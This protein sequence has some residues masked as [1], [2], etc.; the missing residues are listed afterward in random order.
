MVRLTHPVVAQNDQFD[1][2]A[3][4]F[5]GFDSRQGFVWMTEASEASTCV[6]LT[7]QRIALL[8]SSMRHFAQALCAAGRPPSKSA[9]KTK[10]LD[11]AMVQRIHA[12][13]RNEVEATQ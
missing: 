9:R 12:I 8:L 5:N 10:A 3:S 13:R 1:P 11:Q 2:G 7:K 4:V 6:W